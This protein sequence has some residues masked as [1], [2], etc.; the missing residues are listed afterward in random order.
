MTTLMQRPRSTQPNDLLYND[1]SH[2]RNGSHSYLAPLSPTSQLPGTSSHL[3]DQFSSLQRELLGE[4]S[5]S[6]STLDMAGTSSSLSSGIG[7]E[8][9]TLYAAGVRGR[10]EAGMERRERG[11]ESHA[12]VG[13]MEDPAVLALVGQSSQLEQSE[14]G[15][16]IA[17]AQAVSSNLIED[18]PG[19]LSD[20]DLSSAATFQFPE[21][22]ASLLDQAPEYEYVSTRRSLSRDAFNSMLIALVSSS[23]FILKPMS[24]MPS[25]SM[26]ILVTMKLVKFLA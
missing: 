7:A 3:A 25:K 12:S 16:D 21:L 5:A 13:L 22:P 1:R 19:H 20:L 11:D 26:V 9:S 15:L 6:S 10:V 2:S 17:T 23:R 8:H 18:A 14:Y 24:L 4:T